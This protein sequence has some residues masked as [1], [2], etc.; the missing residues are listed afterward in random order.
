MS[1]L[2][3]GVE[4]VSASSQTD[5]EDEDKL[6]DEPV[7]QIKEPYK[8][9]PID[10]IHTQHKFITV[11]DYVDEVENTNGNLDDDDQAEPLRLATVIPLLLPAGCFTFL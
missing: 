7:E 8:E 9:T 5:S 10:A 1:T 6:K 4:K 2:A 11:T 3:S